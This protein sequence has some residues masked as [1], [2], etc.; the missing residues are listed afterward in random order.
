MQLQLSEFRV[1]AAG[2]PMPH[3]VVVRPLMLVLLLGVASCGSAGGGDTTAGS[4]AGPTEVGSCSDHPSDIT[5]ADAGREIRIPMGR[6]S[7]CLDEET[8]PL[9][10]L[11]VSGCP[12]GRVSNL[13]VAGPDQYPTGYEVTSAGACTLRNGD[14]HVDLVFTA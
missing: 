14:F 13:S 7:V 5:E 6:F 8:H 12:V 9:R 3:S 11:D 10:Q 2:R 4:T 1:L